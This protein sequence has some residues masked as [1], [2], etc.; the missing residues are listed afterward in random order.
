M[1]QSGRNSVWLIAAGLLVVVQCALLVH[2]AVRHTPVTDETTRLMA[3][4]RILTEHRFDTEIGNPPLIKTL[5]AIPAWVAS[6][7]TTAAVPI[8]PMTGLSAVK[9]TALGR[10]CVIPFALLGGVICYLWA[11]EL[12]GRPGGF[13]AL[14]LWTTC[15]LV[16]TQGQIVGND[17]AAASATVAACYAFHQWVSSERWRSAALFGVLLGMALLTKFVCA[18]IPV[19]VGVAWALSRSHSGRRWFSPRVAAQLLSMGFIAVV[20][21]NAGYGFQAVIR[22]PMNVLPVDF[23][24][25]ISA[26]HSELRHGQQNFLGGEWRFGGWWYYYIYALSVKLPLGTLAIMVTAAVAAGPLDP[27][28]RSGDRYVGLCGL[29][30]FA[31]ISAVGSI[32]ML[33]YVIPALPLLLIWSGRAV[34]EGATSWSR[35]IGLAMGIF[36]GASSLVTVPHFGSYFNELAGGP[37]A[38]AA[39]LGGDSLDCGEN[40]Y[41]IREWLERNPQESEVFLAYDSPIDPGLVG[42]QYRPLRPATGSS[43]RPE[44]LEPGVYLVPV[45]LLG[46]GQFPELS[47]RTPRASIA[48]TIYVFSV[49]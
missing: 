6:D 32:H 49:P 31:F 46:S 36:S 12:H 23:V 35:V 27:K 17:V 14:A 40:L 25:G 42:I 15:P 33:R 39:L 26:V 48:R 4:I 10:F 18:A 44:S 5:A 37:E 20:I 3:G 22:S 16:L 34:S 30:M 43:N 9:F 11:A 2:G 45:T 28:C 8:G 47:S 13:M 24:Q 19:I 41:F 1:R 29:G 38:G 7:R 21:V